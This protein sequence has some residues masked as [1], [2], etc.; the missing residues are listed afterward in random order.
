MS[1]HRIKFRT[2]R[3]LLCDM[4]IDNPALHRMGDLMQAYEESVKL[5]GNDM[6]RQFIVIGG[7]ALIYIGQ[8]NAT[9]NDL[10]IAV[11]ERALHSFEEIATE[12]YKNYKLKRYQPAPYANSPAWF[13]EPDI[14]IGLGPKL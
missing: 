1:N 13:F 11:T 9:T 5:V 10:D 8:N 2:Y 3:D 14:S 12:K 6:A 7:V 4:G